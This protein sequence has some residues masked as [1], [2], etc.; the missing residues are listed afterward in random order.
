MQKLVIRWAINAL[1]L[2]LAI[3]TNWIPGVQA[4]DTGAAAW[5]GLAL[6]FGLVNALI[7]PLLKFL[8]CPLILVTLGLFTLIINTGLLVLTGWIGQQFGIG[9]TFAEPFFW[10][11]FWGAFLAGLVVSVVSAVMT[12]LLR[13]ELDR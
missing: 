8:T 2:Y 11:G 6:V 10:T 4:Q 9:I 3:G 13:E 7:R 5:L 1:A 12:M